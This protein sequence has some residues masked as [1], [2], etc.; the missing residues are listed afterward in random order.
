MERIR[1]KL[2]TPLSDAETPWTDWKYMAKYEC[3][4]S[5]AQRFHGFHLRR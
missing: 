4:N 3:E 5:S 2:R 1:G